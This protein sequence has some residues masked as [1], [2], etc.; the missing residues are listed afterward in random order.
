MN[1]IIK[2]SNAN[3]KQNAT[4]HKEMN[5]M[6]PDKLVCNRKC[7]SDVKTQTNKTGG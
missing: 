7:N 1:N 5:A 2:F 3:Q 6:Q 4:S